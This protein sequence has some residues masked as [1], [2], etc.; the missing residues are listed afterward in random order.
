MAPES[1][2]RKLA[3]ILACD[4]V[5]YSRL[6]GEDEG[7][8]HAR[9]RALNAELVEPSVVQYGGRVFKTT[10]DGMMIEFASA[11]DAVRHALDVQDG[12]A[13]RNESVPESQRIVLRMGVNLGDVIVE[14]GDVFGDGV[15]VA[16]RLEGFAQ[17]GQICVSED[18]YRQVRGK[19]QADFD[20]LGQQSLKNIAQPV[21]IYRVRSLAENSTSSAQTFTSPAKP[22]I[23][24]LPFD[25]MS[26]DAAQ[27]FFTDGITE[28]IIT[29]LSRFS[30]L[31]VIARNSSFVYKGRPTKLQDVA[32]E[33][34]VHYVVEG[35]VRKSGNRVRIT[36]QLVDGETGA[37]LWAQRYDREITDIFDIQDEIARTIAAT[38]SGRLEAAYAER[39]KRK[40]PEHMAA[41]EYVLAAK[42]LHHRGG[43]EDNAEAQRLIDCA[44]E[45]DPSFAQ[46]HAW[47]CCILGQAW[48]RGFGDPS[49]LR[50][51]G[52]QALRTAIA[53]DPNDLEANRVLCEANMAQ[54]RLDVA[55][56]HHEHA[57]TQNPN[58]P[59]I[60][61]QKGELLTWLGRP[62]EGAA[63][64]E[65]AMRLDPYGTHTRAHLY[66]RALY[67][68]RRYREAAE[69]Y[70]EIPEPRW[71]HRADLAACRAQLGEADAAKAQVAEV[72]RL[73]PAFSIAA[74][75]AT[76]P[77]VRDEDRANV[78][79][80]LIKAGLPD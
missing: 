49:V 7:G 10:G 77:Y 45:A 64:I 18:I 42:V 3:A 25:H 11:V 58:D 19:V 68:L 59:R 5:G 48:Q 23:A 65:A 28:D 54:G 40:P 34:G 2:S 4:V 61:A 66:G 35:S 38:V 46:A 60:V 67:A 72:L 41:Y 20:D 62:D 50:S 73:N 33:L 57:F 12:V 76:L 26:G 52:E 51:I 36:A 75:V 80:G 9:L 71:T 70:S 16:A 53:L 79:E 31:L 6:M 47:K 63:W 39:V 14:N 43:R 69:A 78:R 32:R 22:S 74:Y 30:G 44:I 8:T 15:N 37:H 29:E 27:D 56:R 17:P 55:R 1:V 13:R 24:I 21:R